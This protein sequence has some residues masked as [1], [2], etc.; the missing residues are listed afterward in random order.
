MNPAHHLGLFWG[1]PGVGPTSF[2]RITPATHLCPFKTRIQSENQAQYD[3][4]SPGWQYAPANVRGRSRFAVGV[5]IARH[6][7]IT[8]KESLLCSLLGGFSGHRVN[9][10]DVDELLVAVMESVDGQ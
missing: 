1:S 7:E 4:S 5:G 9:D 10:A 2:P 3:R 8:H 6:M